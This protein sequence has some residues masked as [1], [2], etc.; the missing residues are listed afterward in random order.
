MHNISLTIGYEEN[1]SRWWVIRHDTA[2]QVP[3]DL[4]LQEFIVL[5]A[6]DYHWERCREWP[7]K[8]RSN[9]WYN[10][11]LHLDIEYDGTVENKEFITRW[12][13]AHGRGIVAFKNQTQWA[14]VMFIADWLR[15]RVSEMEQE[16]MMRILTK[17]AA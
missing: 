17:E 2:Y 10:Q 5:Q 1:H 14:D 13:K 3:E 8:H 7:G 16:C 4:T 12:W 9:V 15:E 11:L 6:E